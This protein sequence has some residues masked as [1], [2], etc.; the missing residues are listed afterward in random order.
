MTTAAL[1]LAAVAL[2]LVVWSYAVYP[3]LLGNLSRRAPARSSVAGSWPSVDVLVSAFDEEASIGPRVANLL[4]QEYPGPVTVSIGC[5]GCRDRTAERARE[6]GDARVH[7]TEFSQRRGKAAV[8]DDLVARSTGDVV[9][10]TDA[11]SSFAPDAVT[12][13]V[14]R[15]AD[16]AVGAVCGR[17][18]LD[19]A[20]GNGSSPE[21][22]FW[23]S[24]TRLK[25][26]EGRLGICLGA[27]GAIYAARRELVSPLPPGTALDDFLIPARIAADGHRVE[28]AGDAVA[29]ER[30]STDVASEVAR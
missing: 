22:E 19:P 24:E 23:D 2:I 7:V 8:L 6:A 1:G 26:A 15:F 20:D 14:G 12:R 17:L 9:V 18:R 30:L 5:D 27:N 29:R 11:N 10:F 13:L 21:T 25:E 3:V 4:A 28:F 16:P